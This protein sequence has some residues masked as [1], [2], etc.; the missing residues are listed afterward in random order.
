MPQMTSLDVETFL[1]VSKQGDRSCSVAEIYESE[2]Q[3]MAWRRS[4][5]VG[6]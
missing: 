4:L 1:A 3:E 6:C 2:N 5:E